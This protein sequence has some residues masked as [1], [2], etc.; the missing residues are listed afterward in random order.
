MPT[1][2][3]ITEIK[4]QSLEQQSNE[5]N[6]ASEVASVSAVNT[7]RAVG[8][9]KRYGSRWVFQDVSSEVKSGA[10]VGLLGPYGAG[11]P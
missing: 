7:L 3:E 1:T 11:K 5:K 4:V 10:V 2:E 6:E 8:L 9:K